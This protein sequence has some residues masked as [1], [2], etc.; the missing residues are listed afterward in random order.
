MT[1]DFNM[2]ESL[3]ERSTSSCSWFTGLREDLACVDIKKKYNIDNYF[4]RD[5]D[6]SYSYNNLRENDTRVFATLDRFYYF[7]SF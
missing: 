5:D 6:P 7:S 2:V 3:L 4:N 1:G